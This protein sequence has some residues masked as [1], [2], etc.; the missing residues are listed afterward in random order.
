MTEN[1]QITNVFIISDSVGDT[2]DQVARAAAA[3]FLED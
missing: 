3:Q 1:K 2:G